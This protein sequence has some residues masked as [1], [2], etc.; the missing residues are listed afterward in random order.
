MQ[1]PRALALFSA[2]LSLSILPTPTTAANKPSNAIL[3]SDV[4]SLTFRSQSKTTARRVSPIPQLTCISS[5]QICGL[6]EIDI[7]RCTNQGAG[8]SA[9]DIQWSCAASLPPEFKLGSTD[10]TCEGYASPDDDYVLKGSCGAEYRL[11]LTEAGE[12]RWPDIANGGGGGFSWPWSSG[13]NTGK[14]ST[15]TSQEQQSTD[16]SAYVFGVIFIGVCVWILWSACVAAQDNN[17]P[18]RRARR[19]PRNNGGGGGG[20][21]GFGGG[22]GGGGWFQNDDSDPPPPYS[23]PKSSYSSSSRSRQQ[24]SGS[25]FWSG[26]AAGAAAGSAAGYF[27]GSRGNGNRQQQSGVGGGGSNWSSSSSGSGSGSTSSSRYES[28]GFGGTTRR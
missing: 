1:H 9:Q 12:A 22:G 27:A 15:T 2:L 4:Q 25:G 5:P 6:Y 8:Y 18:N 28:T 20:G 7:L 24:S 10:V 13:K 23:A 14:S 11:V 26:A 17:D 3:L 16:I 21:P 19:R